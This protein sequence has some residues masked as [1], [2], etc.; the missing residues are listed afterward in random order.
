MGCGLGSSFETIR[1]VGVTS[2]WMKDHPFEDYPMVWRNTQLIIKTNIIKERE[3]A[4][5]NQLARLQRPG[6]VVCVATR[7]RGAVWDKRDEKRRGGDDPHTPWSS[8]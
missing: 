6:G 5:T 8:N 7:G 3:G 2:H 1:H 4:Q